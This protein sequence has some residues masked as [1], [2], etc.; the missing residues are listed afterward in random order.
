MSEGKTSRRV[1]LKWLGAS[2]GLVSLL[3][4][5]GLAGQLKKVHFPVHL[6]NQS[7]FLKK[8][9]PIDYKISL[10]DSAHYFGDRPQLKA[11][12]ILWD[13]STFLKNHNLP[14]PEE[15]V[16]L[17]IVGGGMSGLIS[18]YLLRDYRPI[19]LEQSNRFGG[20]AKGEV[21]NGL[22]YSVG[23]A[24]YMEQTP[25]TRLYKLFGEVGAHAICR[26]KDE[27]DPTLLGDQFFNHFW[28]GE[29]DPKRKEQF[30]KLA[31]YFKDV[32]NG[33]NNQKF[34]EMPL[35][36]S[37][38]SENPCMTNYLSDLD[39]YNLKDFLEKRILN[40]EK[41]HPHIETM[42]EH[43]CWSTFACT[44]QDVSAAAGLNAYASEFG[45]VYS[46]PG[47]N[48]AIAECF[49]KKIL[50]TIP[51]RKV[52][53]Q[54]L[55]VN[56]SVKDDHTLITYSD[57]AGALH[58]IKAK[59]AIMACPK[60]VV[61]HILQDVEPERLKAFEKL[62]YRSYLVANALIE[63]K[64]NQSFYDLFLLDGGI[65]PEKSQITDVVSSAYA[66][67]KKYASSVLTLY[68]GFP[69]DSGRAKMYEEES[70]KT[71]KAEMEKQLNE[72]ILPA[73]KIKEGDVK[74]LRITRWGHPMPVPSPGLIADGTIEKIRQPFKNRV[75]FIEQ[76]NWMLA[77]IETAAGEALY[78]SDEIKKILD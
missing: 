77:A 13:K 21:W 58:T 48:S 12:P 57:N 27:E 31:N 63:K 35:P 71:Y 23:A 74:S 67:R 64:E 10:Q 28:S 51:E 39:K 5:K 25:G 7:P 65:D 68:R 50:E 30:V 26:I 15:D 36:L 49:L 11:H 54:S 34:P 70:F 75:F 60:F 43:Y 20:N 46:A 59:V 4:E 38:F 76:D 56:V 3:P 29:T 18:A 73:L 24:Y 61:K 62:K 78:W 55:V 42:L 47:G 32:F 1:F 6:N 8:F 52:R 2:G 17:V 66:P 16:P 72:Q 33:N 69:Y 37:K 9:G 53:A 45:K 19:I 44:L 14:T 40:D 22:P 41:L